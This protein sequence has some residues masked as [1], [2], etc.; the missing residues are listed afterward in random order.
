MKLDEE[1]EEEGREPSM[2]EQYAPGLFTK[3]ARDKGL[4]FYMSQS[5]SEIEDNVHSSNRSTT[6]K[7]GAFVKLDDSGGVSP[8]SNSA[9]QFFVIGEDGNGDA[10]TLQSKREVGKTEVTPTMQEADHSAV[11][12]EPDESFDTNNF[13]NLKFGKGAYLTTT[14]TT[15]DHLSSVAISDHVR[16]S[17]RNPKLV[18]RPKQSQNI[19]Q[20][21]ARIRLEADDGN[22]TGTADGGS[23]QNL[24]MIDPDCPVAQSQ[25]YSPNG[26]GADM[27]TSAMRMIFPDDEEL[28]EEAELKLVSS[29]ELTSSSVSPNMIFESTPAFPREAE[30]PSFKGGSDAKESIAS[31]RQAS[32]NYRIKTEGQ[33]GATGVE[34]IDASASP[35]LPPGPIAFQSESTNEKVVITSV[36]TPM[37]SSELSPVRGKPATSNLGQSPPT[38]RK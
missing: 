37:G 15:S 27:K 33:Q 24:M 36:L 34:I 22:G 2:P 17:N 35:Y 13:T 25:T 29:K 6:R 14:Q 26:V 23:V 1:E 19:E 7:S 8:R 31:S 18:P 9:N 10:I 5:N 28:N 21:R 4:K 16:L 3:T 30:S 11:S 32:G 38:F 20:L 12:P